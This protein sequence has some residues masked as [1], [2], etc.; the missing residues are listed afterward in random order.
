MINSGVPQAI[1]Q[2]FLGHQTAEMTA[3]YA[4]IHQETM[5]NEFQ[6]FNQKLIDT[7][8]QVYKL[9]TDNDAQWLKRNIMAQT[10]PHGLCALPATQQACPHANA[11]LSCAH[12]RTNKKYLCAS[13]EHV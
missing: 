7:K 1:V 11:C 4:H 13:G 3:R 6:K 10:S 2:Q 5:K 8:G 9:D 12:F